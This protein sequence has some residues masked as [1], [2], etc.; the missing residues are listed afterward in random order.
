MPGNLYQYVPKAL[1]GNVPPKGMEDIE[2]ITSHG[3]RNAI[4]R[5]YDT[6]QIL[7]EYDRR[8]AAV[9]TASKV[10]LADLGL[11]TFGNGVDIVANYAGPASKAANLSARLSK[12][13]PYLNTGV[14]LIQGGLTTA[15]GVNPYGGFE[16]APMSVAA[17]DVADSAPAMIGASIAGPVGMA[18]GQTLLGGQASREMM[19]AQANRNRPVWTQN[20]S[21]DQLIGYSSPDWNRNMFSQIATSNLNSEMA[22]RQGLFEKRYMDAKRAKLP[23]WSLKNRRNLHGQLLADYDDAQIDQNWMQK[24][25]YAIRQMTEGQGGTA[26]DDFVQHSRDN[27]AQENAVRKLSADIYFAEN[28]PSRFDKTKDIP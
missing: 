15:S 17:Y 19:I 24:A 11:N 25:Y 10:Q 27:R 5:G 13:S 8:N 3:L 21:E 18:V 22:R 9:D 12:L 23:E 14:N 7:Y 1:Q 26:F 28:P 20:P 16:D 4:V 2:G 6:D